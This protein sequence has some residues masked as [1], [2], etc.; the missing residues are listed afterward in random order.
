MA[1]VITLSDL[2]PSDQTIHF[3]LAT[4]EFDLGGSA[5]KSYETTDADVVSDAVEHPWLDVDTT[6][7]TTKVTFID[8]QVPASEDPFS[9]FGPSAGLANDPAEVAKSEAAKPDVSAQP[10]AIDAG[11]DQN[12]AVVTGGIAETVAGDEDAQPAK[13]AAAFK[14]TEE[15]AVAA[16]APPEPVVA[17]TFTSSDTEKDS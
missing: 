9:R 10:V 2:A 4:A 3:T 7:A 15:A 6:A 11:K 17:S 14:Q 12:V 5:K 13:S 8:T 16:A 1:S